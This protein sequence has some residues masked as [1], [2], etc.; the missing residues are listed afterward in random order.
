M[1][2]IGVILDLILVVTDEVRNASESELG[3]TLVAAQEDAVTVFWNFTF[4][5]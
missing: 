5:G 3:L 4:L 1:N 2:D